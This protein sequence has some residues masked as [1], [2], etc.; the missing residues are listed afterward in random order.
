MSDEKDRNLQYRK[1]LSQRLLRQMNAAFTLLTKALNI[2][3]NVEQQFTIDT[4]N[5]FM[6]LETLRGESLMGKEIQSV[7]NA[8]LRLPSTGN[9]SLDQ[10]QP[11]SLRVR[12]SFNR[13]FHII[14]L[15]LSL[16]LQSTVEPLPLFGSALNT[17]LSR[18]I[19][20]TWMNQQGNELRF[21]TDLDHPLE[22]V[23]PRDPSLIIP[24]MSLVNVTGHQ[25]F[26]WHYLDLSRI[27]SSASV[28]IH[29]EI[30]PMNINISYAFI[31]RFDRASLNHRSMG[32]QSSLRQVTHT[33]ISSLLNGFV[34]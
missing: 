31:Y 22:I 16:F 1:E 27:S 21:R 23:V 15:S 34:E 20:L 10:Q 13:L 3:L 33:H 25:G 30:H 7:G 6:S 4:L 11:G 5:L 9:L 32:G 2:H 28:S 8:R 18:S 12:S 17:N 29:C 14:C 26:H 24:P 19:S